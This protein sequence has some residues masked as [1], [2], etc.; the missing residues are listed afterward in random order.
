MPFVVLALGD[1]GGVAFVQLRDGE[2]FPG[3]EGDFGEPLVAPVALRRQAERGAHRFHG[4]A[5]AL[6]RARHVVERFWLAL[7]AVEQIAQH[8]AAM[9][10]LRAAARIERDV[11]AALQTAGD[12][13]V[14]FAVTDVIDGGRRQKDLVVT[15]GDD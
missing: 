4:F 3:A 7:V 13:P 1:A 12:V 9:R 10:G 14:G 6:E 8:L 5:G 11:A 15:P 2:A